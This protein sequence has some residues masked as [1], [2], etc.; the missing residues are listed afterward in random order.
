MALD[1]LAQQKQHPKRTLIL[2][3]ILETGRSP[4]SLYGE[5]AGL[6]RKYPVDRLIGVGEQI[7]AEA[8]RF[9]ESGVKERIFFQGTDALLD[10]ISV[11]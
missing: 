6:L 10:G 4:E 3:D 2:S 7:S 5:V 11:L 1:F 8:S 9:D